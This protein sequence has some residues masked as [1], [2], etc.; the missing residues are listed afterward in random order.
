MKRIKPNKRLRRIKKEMVKTSPDRT[1]LRKLGVLTLVT[2]GSSALMLGL[3]PNEAHAATENQN[4]SI[5]FTPKFVKGTS[6]FQPVSVGA[7]GGTYD[8]DGDGEVIQ[9][10]KATGNTVVRYNKIGTYS[11]QQVDAI[12]TLTNKTGTVVN[13][14]FGTNNMSVSLDN[15][16]SWSAG[17]YKG[18]DLQIQFVKSGTNTQVDFGSNAVGIAFSDLESSYFYI[19][20]TRYDSLNQ[21]MTSR[22]GVQYWKNLPG[23]SAKIDRN[24]VKSNKFILANGTNVPSWALQTPTWQTT[25]ANLRNSYKD[26]GA[27]GIYNSSQSNIKL[28]LEGYAGILDLF[29]LSDAGITVNPPKPTPQPAPTKKIDYSGSKTTETTLK[30]SKDPYTYEIS[31]NIKRDDTVS[32][33]GYKIVDTIPDGFVVS[34]ITTNDVGNKYFTQTSVADL[35]KNRTF[36][37]TASKGNV[38]ETNQTVT[39]R[40]TGTIDST[41]AWTKTYLENKAQVIVPPKSSG[42]GW[43]NNTKVNIPKRDIT[44]NYIDFDHNDRKL[45]TS[46]VFKN[47][48]VG[49]GIKENFTPVDDITY[50]P[51]GKNYK[52]V[53]GK[54]NGKYAKNKTYNSENTANVTT[55]DLYYRTKWKYY[56]VHQ[57]NGTNPSV[58]DK[59][60]PD[61]ALLKIDSGEM[62]Y[63]T[64][65]AKGYNQISITPQ[66]NLKDSKGR[67][68]LPIESGKVQRKAESDTDTLRENYEH[69]KLNANIDWIQLDTTKADTHKTPMEA[70]FHVTTNRSYPLVDTSK[71]PNTTEEEKKAI[72]EANQV[73]E[74]Y[75][76]LLKSLTY[77]V[78]FDNNTTGSKDVYTQKGSLFTDKTISDKEVSVV[79]KD[80]TLTDT[81]L[82]KDTENKINA[83]VEISN[84]EYFEGDPNTKADTTIKTASEKVLTNSDIKDN[85]INYKNEIRTLYNGNDGKISHYTENFDLTFNPTVNIKTGYYSTSDLS[86]AYK[87]DTDQEKYKFSKFSMNLAKKMLDGDRKSSSANTV[88]GYSMDVTNQEVKNEAF[89]TPKLPDLDT[90]KT[91]TAKTP[92]EYQQVFSDMKSGDLHTETELKTKPSDSK[93]MLNGGR[94]YYV[95]VWADVKPFTATYKTQ[96]DKANKEYLGVN[97]VEINLER[98][99]NVVAQM[100]SDYESGTKGK[101]ELYMQPVFTDDKYDSLPKNLNAKDK[102]WLTSVNDS[103]VKD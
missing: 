12:L 95:P 31:V 8:P 60:N 63:K 101:D 41:T 75:K 43:S 19:N 55:V 64:D 84:P 16:K 23:G 38:Y 89:D 100:Y 83:K 9:S 97:K 71:M 103:S 27:V 4:A 20:G 93:N 67:I 3:N 21:S 54:N 70:R 98:K 46:T 92:V 5:N 82:K 40:I 33:K 47:I 22:T 88:K 62:F 99:F 59:V 26:S 61:G 18:V 79:M 80:K 32:G 76:N 10:Y 57:V 66:T 49:Y 81:K 73:N 13:Y 86:V 52:F 77:G 39:Y 1:R 69:W 44:F 96:D 45:K 58:T 53:E 102:E 24:A 7:K 28:R 34:N 42:G 30:N 36:T 50:S 65:D 25:M 90:W 85:K 68:W 94:K 15:N 2:V 35:N 51:N 56:L 87:A 74:W 6:S 17:E 11:G 72:T 91:T 78:N 37:A 14:W 29:Y 48:P